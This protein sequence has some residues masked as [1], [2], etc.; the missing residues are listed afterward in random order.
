MYIELNCY[1]R[2]AQPDPRRV[3]R[4]AREQLFC[5]PVAIFVSKPQGLLDI[6][7]FYLGSRGDPVS[8]WQMKV[9][10]HKLCSLS[11]APVYTELAVRATCAARAT[12]VLTWPPERSHQPLTMSPA[13]GQ[14]PH[15][16][17]PALPGV[18]M[19]PLLTGDLLCSQQ[20]TSKAP[21]LTLTSVQ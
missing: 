3:R 4:G 19:P 6:L 11:Q 1:F 16:S 18:P 15:P 14:Q 13:Q 12:Q 8:Y 10:H 5:T 9:S 20:Q 2:S 17:A 21:V 7:Q